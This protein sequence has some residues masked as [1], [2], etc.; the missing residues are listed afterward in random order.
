[1]L[2]R[3]KRR[4]DFVRAAKA[5]LHASGPAMAL[6]AYRR[7]A[8]ES[9]DGVLGDSIRV[10]FTTS[11]KVGNAVIRNRVRRRLREVA[12]QVLPAEGK[13]GHDYVL[14]GRTDAKD[15]DFQDLLADVRAALAKIERKVAGRGNRKPRPPNEGAV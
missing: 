10:G 11:K 14:V 3:L 1:M 13:P 12:E 6:Q 5:G 4:A 2:P 15:R 9:G 7:R 8:N